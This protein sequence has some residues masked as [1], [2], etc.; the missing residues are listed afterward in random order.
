MDRKTCEKIKQ[1]SEYLDDESIANALK[2]PVDVVRKAVHGQIEDIKDDRTNSVT[3]VRVLEMP[4]F[5]RN[6]TVTAVSPGGG[7]GKTTIL[8]SLAVLAALNCSSHRPVVVADF[9]EFSKA[10]TMLGL[11][12]IEALLQEYEPIP[13]ALHWPDGEPGQD[14]VLENLTARHSLIQNL[15]FIHGTLVAGMECVPEKI[16]NIT[17]ALQKNFEMVFIDLPPNPEAI[18]PLC[19][20]VL[21][22]LTP[23]YFSLEGL[24][25]LMPLLERWSVQ[26]K[27]IPVLNR[28]SPNSLNPGQCRSVLKNNFALPVKFEGFIPEDPN[29]CREAPYVTRE[30]QFAV[31]VRKLLG[32]LCPDWNKKKQNGGL[33]SMLKK[34]VRSQEGKLTW[35]RRY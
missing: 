1:M 3:R 29:L 21:V 6:K 25:Q 23:D 34:F 35:T 33:S 27:A 26:D 15:H 12:P 20:V 2:L 14:E 7:K 28:I 11:K 30:S 17:K 9:S 18:L 8:T 19:D 10:A 13:T 22:V 32:I 4:K 31:E 24:F 5:V 16:I